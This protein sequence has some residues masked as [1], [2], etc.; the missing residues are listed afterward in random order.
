MDARTRVYAVFF[1]GLETV[2]V[3]VVI[4]GSHVSMKERER[5]REREGRRI[6]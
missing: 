6:A 2:Y 3:S 4:I 1:V 5:E